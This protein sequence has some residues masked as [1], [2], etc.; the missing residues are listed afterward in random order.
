MKIIVSGGGSGEDAKEQDELF[1]NLLDKS[2]PLI[3]IPI[4]M[5]ITDH[6]YPECLEWLKSNFERFGVTNY[7]MFDINALEKSNEINLANY[8]GIYIGGGNTPFLLNKL[9][10]T[11]FWDV[12]KKAI[13]ED[14]P[15]MGGSAGAII[16]AKS[17]IPSLYYDM[18][19]IELKDFEAMNSINDWEIT[20]HY[21]DEEEEKVKK[22]M[23]ENSFSKLVALTNKNGLY[24]NDE[25]IELIGHE[26]AW[27]FNQEGNKKE[28]RVGEVLKSF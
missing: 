23:N 10:Q 28:M 7:E 3:Y 4:A 9:K 24:V 22:I 20:C 27:I 15:I 13:K 21:I 26:S 6:S 17:I 16:F 25:K 12:L 19:W 2:K 8:S 11:K 14:L 18:N 5:D 1:A